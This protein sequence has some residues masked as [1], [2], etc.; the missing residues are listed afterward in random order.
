MLQTWGDEERHA[1]EDV[2][3]LHLEFSKNA[4]IKQARLKQTN[5]WT[6]QVR[7]GGKECIKFGVNSGA[8][9]LYIKKEER[10]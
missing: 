5:V 1:Q 7:S 2:G 4:W 8:T 9:H 3:S 10:W 6:K